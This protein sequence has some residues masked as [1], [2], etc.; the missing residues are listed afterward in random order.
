MLLSLFA[1]LLINFIS[2]FTL[3]WFISME[4]VADKK[5]PGTNGTIHPLHLL[6]KKFFKIQPW[7]ND[8]F[9]HHLIIEENKSHDKWNIISII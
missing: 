9:Y 6:V 8:R 3:Q 1:L 4:D 5:W 7:K 2:N